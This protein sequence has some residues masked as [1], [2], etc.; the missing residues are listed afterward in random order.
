MDYIYFLKV[1]IQMEMKMDKKFITGFFAFSAMFMPFCATSY[2]HAEMKTQIE[3]LFRNHPELILN[4]LSDHS[5]ELL[6][7][8][9]KASDQRRKNSFLN[10]WEQDAKIQKSVL[11]ENRAYMGK[12]SAPITIVEYTDFSC[13]Y[14]RKAGLTVANVLRKHPNS[15]RLVIKL[16]GKTEQ[17]KLAAEW[18]YT[19]YQLDQKKAWILYNLIFEGQQ[20]LEEQGVEY[21]KKVALQAGF[22]P[23]ELKQRA[24]EKKNDIQALMKLDADEAKRLGF[25]GTPYFLINNLVARGAITE[26]L[27]ES[28]IEVAKR[29]LALKK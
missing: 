22:T 4:V 7:I 27:F 17:S 15:V 14:C 6:N 28:A 23:N 3:L 18:F 12:K 1:H 8:L 25:S 2:A 21:L 10:Q 13:F 19:A 11:V 24:F 20:K 16:A 5:E 9:Q 26:D 29:H